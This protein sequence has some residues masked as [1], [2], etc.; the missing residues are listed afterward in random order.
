MI[1]NM[2]HEPNAKHMLSRN[3]LKFD[4]FSNFMSCV[5]FEEENFDF[6][7]VNNFNPINNPLHFNF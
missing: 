5:C 4:H 3:G 1:L 2:L 6:K 7:W